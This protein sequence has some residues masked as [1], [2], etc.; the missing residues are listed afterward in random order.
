MVFCA[1]LL[2]LEGLDHHQNV[3]SSSLY[4][5][6]PLHEISSQSICNYLSNI[7]HKQTN[8]RTDRQTNA[9]KNVSSFAKEVISEGEQMEPLYQPRHIQHSESIW[10][11]YNVHS[12]GAVLSASLTFHSLV[13]VISQEIYGFFMGL[14]SI[15]CT[16][17][18]RFLSRF[19][20][21]IWHKWSSISC[22]ISTCLTDYMHFNQSGKLC[23]SSEDF[24]SYWILLFGVGG[25]YIELDS[26]DSGQR[27][28]LTGA[29]IKNWIS[30]EGHYV[31]GVEQHGWSILFF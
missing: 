9:T 21:L 7:I 27:H 11:T 20:T 17:W 6:W 29:E 1:H 2:I 24:F 8:R 18:T 26:F 22:L 13:I 19:F 14:L 3:I 25:L 28:A 10:R 12:V 15:W 5:P 4:Y 31:D 23:F 30:H 16:A